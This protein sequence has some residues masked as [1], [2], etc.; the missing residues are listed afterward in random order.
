MRYAI[1][2]P[3][4]IKSTYYLRLHV[5]KDIQESAQGRV[6]HI[7]VSDRS[8][9]DHRCLVIAERSQS[10]LSYRGCWAPRIIETARANWKAYGEPFPYAIIAEFDRERDPL[11]LNPRC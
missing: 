4:L 10:R 11:A 6:V 7:P 5:P 9:S 3:E 2:N 8:G 1:P